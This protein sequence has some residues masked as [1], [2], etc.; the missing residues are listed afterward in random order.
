MKYST[1]VITIL[2]TTLLI[3]AFA[4]PQSWKEIL[5]DSKLKTSLLNQELHLGLD[6]QG[7][8]QLDYVLDLRQARKYNNDEDPSND[9]VIEQLVEGVRTTLE[10]RVNGLGVSEPNIYTAKI[11]DENHVIVELAGIDDLE[12][13]KEIVGKT[14]QLEFKEQKEEI[15]TDEKERIRTA[16]Q[17]T[18]EKALAGDNF[19]TLGETTKTGDQKIR[20]SSLEQFKGDIPSALQENLWNLQAGSVHVELIEISDGYAINEFQQVSEQKG[21][22]IVK[23]GEKKLADKEKTTDGEDFEIVAKEVSGNFT[24]SEITLDALAPEIRAGIAELGNTE[25]SEV[26]ETNDAYSVYKLIERKDQE[27]EVRA[28][29]MLIAY[30][31][32]ERSSETR[33]KVEARKIIEGLKEEV[34]KDT[35]RFADIAEENSDGP[36][37]TSG[38]DLGF[39]KRGAMAPEFEA[40]AW[41]LGIEEVSDITETSFGFHLIQKT[42]EKPR[43]ETLYTL[44]KII[45]LKTEENAKARADEL[46]A[47]V[48][49]KTETIQEEQLSY[50]RIFYSTVPDAWKS[51]GLD[52]DKFVRATVVFDQVGRPLVSIEFNSEGGKMFEEI[53]DRNVGKPIAIFVGGVLISAPNVNEK[54]SGGA[55]QITGSYT[56]PEAARLAQDL[57]TGAISAPII[58]VGQ[59]QI[60]ATLGEKAFNTSLLAGAIGLML[61]AIYMIFQYRLFGLIANT[62]LLI[63]AIILLFILKSSGSIGI[64]IVLTLAGIA[65]LILS[66]GMAVDA[67]ILIFE[68]VKE[69]LQDGKKISAALS[70]GFERAWTS[71]RDSNISSLI[72][73]II[74]AWFG[75]SI[76]RGF[77]I[78]LAIGILVSMFTA[79]TIT[80]SFLF[81]FFSNWQKNKNWLVNNAEKKAKK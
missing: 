68:R 1:K 23:A 38:G 27:E 24:D 72:T 28:R 29:H 53:T 43:G 54:I 63:Y 56:I 74:L 33:S 61:L 31:G 62:A 70:I 67:N 20:Y 59:H 16:A 7:G 50:E 47:R 5:P 48:M 40:A 12:E 9:V 51:T 8:A 36:S 65:G 34:L 80:R 49:P 60:G 6:L 2:V 41:S 71:I 13:A 73:C 14:I 64:P 15:D 78:N 55:A 39:F 32:A 81:C 10:R 17:K 66:I 58:L 22:V 76:I 3:G 77:A 44:Q 25:V 18:L 52:G 45:V 37:S 46:R 4:M 75:S 79:I 69:E 57:N 30:E 35:D 11:A 21:F 26:L 19:S 42:A